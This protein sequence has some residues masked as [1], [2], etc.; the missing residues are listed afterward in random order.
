MRDLNPRFSDLKY[1]A[2]PTKLTGHTVT[3]WKNMYITVK[4]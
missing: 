4:V 2:L 1:E 3:A